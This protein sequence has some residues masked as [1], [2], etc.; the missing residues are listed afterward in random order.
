[1]GSLDVDDL[2]TVKVPNR[3]DHGEL[4]SSYGAVKMSWQFGI[5]C[6]NA[7][8]PCSVTSVSLVFR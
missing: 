1:L 8:A 6:L 5:L 4:V 7:L 2:N 3:E